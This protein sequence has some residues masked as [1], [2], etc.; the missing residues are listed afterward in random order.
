MNITIFENKIKILIHGPNLHI[1]DVDCDF[2]VEFT[3]EKEPNK[4]KL[5]IYNLN[6]ANMNAVLNNTLYVEIFTN[7]YGLKDSENNI[8]W[9]TAFEGLLR[10]AEKK[11]KPTK[12]GKASKA[13]TKY[14][15]PSATVHTDDSDIYIELDLQ[16]GDGTDIGTFVS[17]SYRK[18]FDI[19]K[20]LTDL[21]SSIGME[22]VF[23]KNIKNFLLTYPIILHDNIRNSLSQ[24]ASYIDATCTISNNR[25]YV[26][27]NSPEGVSSY[28][29]FDEENIQQPKYLQDK[30]I[31]FTAPYI[32]TVTVGS[33]IKLINKKMEI[34]DV[35][36]VCKIESKF[37]NYSEDC[38]TK[39]TV[40]Y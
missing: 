4:C 5:K 1:E 38:E 3:D 22:I 19:K 21:A 13:K 28:F 35:Y 16:E 6:E 11:P 24:V 26:V 31:E 10:K 39:I 40:K 36:Q 12:S 7:Q 29:Q 17:K 27:G 20:I 14:L 32:P 25:V 37:S 23:D 30:K 15:T 8:L 33:F 9:Q 2:E 34:D 18:G